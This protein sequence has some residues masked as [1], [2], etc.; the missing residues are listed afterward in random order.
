MNT[1]VLVKDRPCRALRRPMPV[2]GHRHPTILRHAWRAIS[3]ALKALA[4]GVAGARRMARA[5]DEFAVMS[6]LELHDI[7]VNRN[8]ISAVVSGTYPRTPPPISDF[9]SLVRRERSL[10]LERRD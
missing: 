1:L 10:S 3:R 4:E 8:D 6:E 7:D 5:Y 9:T 2:N